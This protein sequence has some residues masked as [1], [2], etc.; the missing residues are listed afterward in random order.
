MRLT[1]LRAENFLGLR[2]ADLEFDRLTIVTGKNGAG[3]SSLRDSVLYALTGRARSTDAAGRG[4]DRL[5]RVGSTYMHVR[6]DVQTEGQDLVYERNMAAGGKSSVVAPPPICDADTIEAVLDVP[7]LLTVDAKTRSSIL[8]RLI[9]PPMTI[10][11]LIAV[12]DAEGASEAVCRSLAAGLKN[13]GP[14]IGPLQLEAAYKRAY[15]KRR[16]TKRDLDAARGRLAA[17]EGE[18]G[19]APTPGELAAATALVADLEAKFHTAIT[20]AAE[21][22][23]RSEELTRLADELARLNAETETV[24]PAVLDFG[25]GRTP[26]EL[27]LITKQA[28]ASVGRE[29]SERDAQ[30]KKV[31]AAQK[32]CDDLALELT[33]IATGNVACPSIHSPADCPLSVAGLEARKAKLPELEERAL[34]AAAKLKPERAKLTTIEAHLANARMVEVNA[35]RDQQEATARVAEAKGA[36]AGSAAQIAKRREWVESRIDEIGDV[37]GAAEAAKA[38]AE[39]LDFKLSLERDRLSDLKRAADAAGARLTDEKAVADLAVK[40][41]ILE[42]VVALLDPKGLPAKVVEGQSARF[43]YAVN[44]TLAVLT[45]GEYEIGIS[46]GAKG[47]ELLVHRMV[48]VDLK[49]EAGRTTA[50]A[51]TDQALPVENLITSERMRLGLSLAAAICALKRLPLVI[52][53]AEILDSEGKRALQLV[54]RDLPPEIE[55]CVVIATADQPGVPSGPGRAAYWVESGTVRRIEAP[56]H[57]AV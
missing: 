15:E 34:K 23:A 27:M 21:L 51:G 14:E 46:A 11:E 35:E 3:K 9:C 8:S 49:D 57:A 40:V 39:D 42:G 25:P 18:S 30:Q 5:M 50:I 48:A 7:H 26:M 10:P 2:E 1:T 12:A 31:D 20:V 36:Q 28:R 16:D 19:A 29:E 24:T 56:V 43:T 4:A 38:E 47:V 52:D 6:L 22:T 33:G 45:R 17:L 37:T 13:D 41:A 44:E 32:A 54:L 55:T 53:D